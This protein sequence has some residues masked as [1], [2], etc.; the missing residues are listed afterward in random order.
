MSI[1]TQTALILMM[2]KK[3]CLNAKVSKNKIKK[4]RKKQIYRRAFESI[5]HVLSFGEK[6]GKCR[7]AGEIF[8]TIIEYRF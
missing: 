7:A 2:N 4:L 3:K 1:Y 5:L 6:V 8:F